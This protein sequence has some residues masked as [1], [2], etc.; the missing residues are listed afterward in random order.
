MD[1]EAEFFC[2][3]TQ[4]MWNEGIYNNIQVIQAT[5]DKTQ[6]GIKIN[7]EFK[8]CVN[9]T[10][11]SNI[12]EKL[13]T[14]LNYAIE[15]SGFIYYIDSNN[16]LWEYDIITT[17]IKSID[18]FLKDDCENRKITV[19][20]TKAV[21]NKL[22]IVYKIGE[23]YYGVV[24]SSIKAR[25]L[26][27]IK[28]N[29]DGIKASTI[30][31]N[32]S[33]YVLDRSLNVIDVDINEEKI[34]K[35][36]LKDYVDR[37]CI[38]EEVIFSVYKDK[39][40]AIGNKNGSE[41]IVISIKDRE[42]MQIL[43]KLEIDNMIFA[44]FSVSGEL[45]INSLEEEKIIL[46]NSKDYK[47]VDL[48]SY[49]NFNLKNIKIINDGRFVVQDEN[50]VLYIFKKA[51][52][53]K[54]Q[55]G[56]KNYS[57]VFYSPILDTMRADMKWHKI[58]MDADIPTDTQ[59]TVCY[60]AFDNLDIKYRDK[61]YNI[62]EFVK[63]TVL[64]FEEKEEFFR[65]V[66]V[67]KL[68][69]C[70]EGLFHN[71]N[72][73]YMILRIKLSGRENCN[74][75][76]NK[77]KIYYNRNSYIKY[78]P[79][80]YQSDKDEDDFLE[81]YLSLFESFY[82]D[83]EEKIEYISNNFDIDKANIEFLMWISRW[84]G[85]DE[86]SYWQEDKLRKLLK[87]AAFLCKKKGTKKAIEEILEIYL[88]TKVILVEN[89]EIEDMKKENDELKD[90]LDNLYGNNPYGFVV[91]INNIGRLTSEQMSMVNRILKNESPAYCEFNVVVLKDWIFL[92]EHSYLGVNS[93]ISGYKPLKLDGNAVLPYNAVLTDD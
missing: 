78:L 90:V 41:L 1:R 43:N 88:D 3:N 5:R 52:K 71:A 81:R 85:L 59:I 23:E 49:L 54:A 40:L 65:E 46:Y 24:Y 20:N 77:I 69:N 31:C 34:S 51:L 72:G 16:E 33:V 7:E 63:S 48:I 44:E 73:R 10:I 6:Q 68:I 93:I 55:D 61:V 70:K 15:E 17:D 36:S 76:I 42:H 58:M 92:D 50:D 75:I 32:G 13:S 74:P 80:I 86:Y 62:E 35:F 12:R 57:G 26:N 66:W 14:A 53:V 38:E 30:N 27:K 22:Y 9:K 56:M 87:R 60:Y 64:T 89:F 82:I 11:K 37:H 47:D 21:K 28:L 67:D 39:I 84:M 8:Y 79:E 18:K 91:L 25:T 83:I 29:I 4:E 45:I 19:L 2:I